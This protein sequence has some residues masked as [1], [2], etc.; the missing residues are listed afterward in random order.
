MLVAA[1]LLAAAVVGGCAAPGVQRLQGAPDGMPPSLRY[2][3]A[4]VLGLTLYA[5]DAQEWPGSTSIAADPV[6]ERLHGSI[7]MTPERVEPWIGDHA[8]IVVRQLDVPG[9]DDDTTAY[10]ADVR[11]RGRLVSTLDDAGWK[12]DDDA[13][14]PAVNGD[15]ATLATRGDEDGDGAFTAAALFDDGLLVARTEDGLRAFLEAADEYAVPERRAMSKYAAH[16]AET[17]PAGA[18]FRFDFLRTQL[19]RPFQED[20]ALLEFARWAT[21]SRV[22]LATRDGWFGLAPAGDDGWARIVGAVE[23]VPDLAPD[24][25][26]GEADRAMLD[27]SADVSVAFD[28]AGQHLAELVRGI[29]FNNGQYATEQDVQEGAERVELAELLDELDGASALHAGEGRVA[30]HVRGGAGAAERVDEFM[31]AAG[32]PGG[33]AALD[34]DLVALLGG[35]A[36][37]P[38]RVVAP[39]RFADAQAVRPEPPKPPSP[40]IIW[41]SGRSIAGCSGPAAG[42]VTFDGEGEMTFTIGIDRG[43]VSYRPASSDDDAA[44]SAA[45]AGGIAPEFCDLAALVP[46]T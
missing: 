10:V 14:L 1:A 20:P 3:T 26:W 7:G 17:V 5:T 11:D 45:A 37:D 21:E 34:G 42:W 38:G 13:Q 30:L 31:C 8:G 18:V 27:G 28:D 9:A 2:V 25:E 32:V 41:L 43:G 15:D 35:R 16:V 24:V 33:A 29:T 36:C 6:L 4:D 12:V 46:F 22:L 39:G 19:R 44:G 23:W 40:P